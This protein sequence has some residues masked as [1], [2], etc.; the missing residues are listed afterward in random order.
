MDIYDD[1]DDTLDYFL[2]LFNKIVKEHVPNY[3][4]KISPKDKPFLTSAVKKA[5]R[6]RNRFHKKWK[7]KQ[8]ITA[9]E[10]YREKRL[11]ANQSI[12]EA[13]HCYYEKTKTKLGDPN[14][15]PKQ[16]YKLIKQLYGSKI[17]IGMPSLVEGDQIISNS[18][19]KA[20]ILNTHFVEKAK[21]PQNLPSLP[22]ENP[23]ENFK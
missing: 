1:I 3:T 9:Y 15:N 12:R 6:I 19:Q 7:N 13:K 8:T 22:I 18:L 10:Q 17:E 23:P 11:L 14:L 20:E 2:D 21:L 16:Y 5:I 4:V